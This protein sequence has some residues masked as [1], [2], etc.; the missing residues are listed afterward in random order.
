MQKKLG[1]GMKKHE[2]ENYDMQETNRMVRMKG[3]A[4]KQSYAKKKG[5]EW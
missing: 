1:V 2:M 3:E 5:I 4:G